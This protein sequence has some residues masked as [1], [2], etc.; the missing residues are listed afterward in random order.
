MRWRNKMKVND[1]IFKE[2][3][4]RGYKL[5]GKTRVWDVADSKLWYL[6][7]EQAQGFLDLE[8]DENYNRSIIEKEILLI[9]KNLPEMIKTL[10]FTS[11]NLIDLGCGDGSKA[12]IFIK[13]L[14]K[15][16]DLRY[17]PIDISS[18]MVNKAAQKI[19][20]LKLSE[21][22]EFQWNIS[23]FENLD[24]VTPLFRGNN[25]KHNFLLL[26]G[27][28]LGNFDRDDMLSGIAKS[29][30]KD[31]VLLIG[32]GIRDD[33]SEE[34]L[35]RPYKDKLIDKF[36][37]YVIKQ[38]GLQDSDVKYDARFSN[39]RVEMI[40]TITRDRKILHLGKTVEFKKD[41]VIV[42][43]ISLKYSKKELIDNLHKFFS[44]VKTY[45]DT[46]NAYALAIC[47]K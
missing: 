3:I 18:Y 28:T 6:I 19:R 23:D 29:M 42:V 13:E 39:S 17:C 14:K 1:L 46:K 22:L 27:N 4:K 32:N 35:V 21:V 20:E 25:F 12:S 37:I 11:Y 2:L 24:N 38:I 41:D 33:S 10:P 43:A 26:L 30:I 5:E 8:E 34:E 47:K 16:F 44:N 45:T 9:K 31:D 15:H 40:Y 36:L 7:P